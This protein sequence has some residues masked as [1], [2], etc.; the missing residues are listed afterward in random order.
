MTDREPESDQS[1]DY[2]SWQGPRRA[3]IERA[4][5]LSLRERLEEMQA[6]IDL[7]K[8]FEEMRRKRRSN[9]G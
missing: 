4:R 7:G 1:W 8:R 6:L 5:K 3:M 9:E 2:A